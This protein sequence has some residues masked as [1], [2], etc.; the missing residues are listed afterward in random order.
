MDDELAQHPIHP[1]IN[2]QHLLLGASR[3]LVI[4]TAMMAFA[5]VIALMSLQG[6]AIAAG[7]WLST[8]VL[9]RIMAKQDPLMWRVFLRSRGHKPFY[10]AK[11]GLHVKSKSL[12]AR[13]K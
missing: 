12:P 5:I 13:W 7:F 2:R 6:L 8:L 10:P 11:S 4:F 9:L 1:S 3:E